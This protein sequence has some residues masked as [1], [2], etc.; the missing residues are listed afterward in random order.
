MRMGTG[1]HGATR[2]EGTLNSSVAFHVTM[3]RTGWP[4]QC[5][6]RTVRSSYEDLHC[7]YPKL[8]VHGVNG[9]LESLGTALQDRNK[10]IKRSPKCLEYRAKLCP[11]AGVGRP[12][13][14]SQHCRSAEMP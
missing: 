10:H 11:G 13:W 8:Q 2:F 1:Y 7:G 4:F 9:S 5:L 3:R 12:A 6:T 14:V